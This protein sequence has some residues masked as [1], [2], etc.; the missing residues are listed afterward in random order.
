MRLSGASL[1]LLVIVQ[2]SPPGR[3]L[4]DQLYV[5]LLPIMV[6]VGFAPSVIDPAAQVSTALLLVMLPL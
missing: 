1:L 3:L 5:T 2:V 4:D 6:V